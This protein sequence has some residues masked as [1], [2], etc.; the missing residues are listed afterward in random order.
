MEETFRE[1]ETLPYS[2]RPW[3]RVDGAVMKQQLSN[4]HIPLDGGSCDAHCAKELCWDPAAP[5]MCWDGGDPEQKVRILLCAQDR[6][7]WLFFTS[8]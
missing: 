5:G 6:R 8:C 7:I 1:A 2:W 4:Q 3:L